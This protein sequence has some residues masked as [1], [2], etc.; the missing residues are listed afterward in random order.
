[1]RIYLANKIVAREG[2][3]V[4]YLEPDARLESELGNILKC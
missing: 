4:H 1:M 2:V 3:L